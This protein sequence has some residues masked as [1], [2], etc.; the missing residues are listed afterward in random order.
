MRRGAASD[1]ESAHAPH[2]TKLIRPFGVCVSTMPSFDLSVIT[3]HAF[4]RVCPRGEIDLATAGILDTQI[5]ELWATGW[6]DVLVDL[7]E[8]TFLDSS[9]LHVLLAHH[10]GA[11]ERGGRFSIIDG[12]GP[13][14]RVLALTGMDAV[15]DHAPSDA[16]R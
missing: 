9:G 2:T 10:R 15:F 3:E 11:A 12:D 16:V 1:P 13:V 4:V 8:V 7:R 5:D 14:A 6:T